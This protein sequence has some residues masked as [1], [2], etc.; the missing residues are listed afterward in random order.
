MRK[1]SDKVD[2]LPPS[3]EYS[4]MSEK[5]PPPVSFQKSTSVPVLVWVLL[6]L[7][8]MLFLAGFITLMVAVTTG[9]KV[10]PT[11]D[12]PTKDEAGNGAGST[13][14]NYSDEAGRANLPNFLKKVQSEYYALNS[15][16]VSWQPGIERI[17]DHV[18]E[19]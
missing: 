2:M 6:G 16:E 1:D 5:E 10:C 18:R 12:T 8:S 3:Y 13:S 19:R 4:C 15:H 7:A 14:C 11:K 9:S 17:D